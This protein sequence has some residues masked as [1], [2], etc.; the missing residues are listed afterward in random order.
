MSSNPESIKER[1]AF[2]LGGRRPYPWGRP[3][4]LA[5]PTIRKM[6]REGHLPT[7]RFLVNIQRAENVSLSWLLSGQGAPF[8]IN[9]GPPEVV[10]R[11]IG[12]LSQGTA[13]PWSIYVPITEGHLALIFYRQVRLEEGLPEIVETRVFGGCSLAATYMEALVGAEQALESSHR[14]VMAVRMQR[15]EWFRLATGWTGRWHLFGDELHN[16]PLFGVTSE[17]VRSSDALRAL[18]D[19]WGGLRTT[20]TV[21][22]PEA[23]YGEQA[24]ILS[25]WRALGERER[26]QAIRIVRALRQQGDENDGR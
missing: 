23:P 14:P 4:G 9:N 10:I 7:F 1:L 6:W 3:L 2:L 25:A 8:L 5:D 20:G 15:D 16:E 12:N 21:A 26:A 19:K 11:E 22:E 13:A 24:A 18:V 17:Q